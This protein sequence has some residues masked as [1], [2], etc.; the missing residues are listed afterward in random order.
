MNAAEHVID[1]LG[2]TRRAAALINTSPSTV[3]SWKKTGFIPSRRQA[4][5]VE[6]ARQHGIEISADE[7]LGLRAGSQVAA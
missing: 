5:V 4:E 1:R 6:A 2:G 3:Q 7:M